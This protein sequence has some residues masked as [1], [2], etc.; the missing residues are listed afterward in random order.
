MSLEIDESKLISIN[1]AYNPGW[2][3]RERTIGIKFLNLIFSS[4]NSCLEELY[5]QGNY[6]SSEMTEELTGRLAQSREVLKTLR[7]I[8]LSHSAN[9]DTMEAVNNL[10][11]VLKGARKLELCDISAQRG[12]KRHLVIS[13]DQ[14]K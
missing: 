1:L 10:S 7:I 8:N 12:I 13:V 9:F 4:D 2:W 5:L 14:G 11:D 6:F 3:R